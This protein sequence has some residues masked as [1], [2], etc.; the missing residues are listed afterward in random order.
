MSRRQGN[1]IHWCYTLFA[2]STNSLKQTQRNDWTPNTLLTE[3]TNRQAPVV[4]ILLLRWFLV[5]PKM[6][7]L[8]SKML[9]MLKITVSCSYTLQFHIN[10]IWEYMKEKRLSQAL[11][12]G[13]HFFFDYKKEKAE[14]PS[15][16]WLW[17]IPQR[18]LWSGCAR[19]S[20]RVTNPAR[21]RVCTRAPGHLLWEGLPSE[22]AGCETKPVCEVLG[23]KE[24]RSDR[25]SCSSPAHRAAPAPPGGCS[26][27]A[28]LG[29]LGIS[30]VS[31]CRVTAVSPLCHPAQGSQCPQ[32]RGAAPPGLSSAVLL[33]LSSS[34][35][36]SLVRGVPHTVR[37]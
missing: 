37:T 11:D 10:I 18:W 30:P 35:K 28:Q 15:F 1:S 4:H 5:A 21:G 22:N 27:W 12:L 20:P 9:K 14:T 34:K 31:V 3:S 6:T 32:H 33:A 7:R 16:R 26:R 19:S 2:S 8:I 23:E 24:A 13:T 29:M 17:F 25:I 36:N